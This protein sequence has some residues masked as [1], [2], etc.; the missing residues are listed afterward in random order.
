MIQRLTKREIEQLHGNAKV[1]VTI[2][3]PDKPRYFP[4]AIGE[5]TA[6]KVLKKYG[7][8]MNKNGCWKSKKGKYSCYR[9]RRRVGIGL[10]H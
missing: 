7:D 3:R 2:V 9:V 1:V 6:K 5:F 10:Y 4:E 8:K